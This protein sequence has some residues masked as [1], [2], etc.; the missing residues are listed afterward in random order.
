MCVYIDVL[1]FILLYENFVPSNSV[2]NELAGFFS[3][4]LSISSF[5]LCRSL[6]NRKTYFAKWIWLYW[7]CSE[8]ASYFFDDS[9]PRGRYIRYLLCH[10]CIIYWFKIE[11][12]NQTTKLPKKTNIELN[13]NNGNSIQLFASMT[14]YVW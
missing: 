7:C 9:W 2:N 14:W 1:F 11:K 12:F 6:S 4:S 5:K 3:V 10:L 13:G 8:F